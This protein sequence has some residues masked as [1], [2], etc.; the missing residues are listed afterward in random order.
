MSKWVYKIELNKVIS[1]MCEEYDL[2]RMEEIC[3][4]EVKKA[5]AEEIIKVWPLKRYGEMILKSRTIAELNRYLELVYDE[6]DRKRVWCGF[7]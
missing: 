1:Q 2:S 4:E 6:A 3:P 7:G 5:I